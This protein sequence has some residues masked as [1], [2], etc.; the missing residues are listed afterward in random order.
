MFRGFDRV[1]LAAAFAGAM[2]P[3]G[4]ALRAQSATDDAAT[5]DAALVGRGEYL[6]RAADCMPCHTGDKTKP[7]GGGLGLATPFGT[8]YSV[9]ITSDKATGIGGW[10]F[11]DFKRALHN[12]IRADGAYLYPAMPFDAFTKIE[13]DDLRALWAYIRRLAPVD[14]PNCEN[15]LEFPFNVRLGMIAWRELFF[16]PGY[17]QPTAGKSPEWSRGGYLVEALAH[18]SDCHSPRDVMGAIKGKAQF[19]GTKIDGFYAPNIASAALAKNWSHNDLVQFLKTGTAPEKTTVLGPMATVVHDSLAYLTP[20]DL[21]DIATWLLDSPPPP[22]MPAPEKLSPLPP[23]TYRRAAELYIDN[24]AACHQDHGRGIPGAVPPLADNPAVTAAEPY[25]VIT[26]ALEGLKPGGNYGAMPSFAG[27]LSD[28]RLA[29]LVNYVRTSWGNQ[30][31]AN[32]TPQM[33]AAWRSAAGVPDYG[34]Q[35]A[36]GF[37]CPRLGGAPGTPGANPVAVSGLSALLHAGDNRIADLVATYKRVVPGAGPA[38]VVNALIAADCPVVAAK[39]DPDWQ[40]AAE[41][42]SFALQVAAEVSPQ[43]AAAPIP[44]VDVIWASP[45]GR[46]LVYREPESFGGPLACPEDTAHLVPADLVTRAGA[47]IGKPALPIAGDTAA[48]LALRFLGQA[49]KAPPADLANALI[50]AYCAEVTAQ[51]PADDALQRAWMQDFGAQ[52]VQALQQ[53]TMSAGNGGAR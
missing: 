10:S 23:A 52:I 43:A 6:A 12:G 39:G 8:I 2:L 4:V 21:G 45:A 30:G 14:A 50:A 5:G 44:A 37:E 26:V 34:S 7:Y 24:C 41:L 38:E 53:R 3:G 47:L 49:P 11:A 36:S 31:T 35:A 27:R 17:Y 25:N 22:D 32:A 9:N 13:D 42:H 1:V 29:D 28:D 20:A 46:S 19:T 40:K 48:G 33:V 15:Q 18:C 16:A 51:K